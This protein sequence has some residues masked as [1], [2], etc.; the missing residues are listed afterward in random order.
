MY[1]ILLV[2]PR[3]PYTVLSAY[4]YCVHFFINVHYT[5]TMSSFEYV[6]TAANY[7]TYITVRLTT[8]LTK[9]KEVHIANIDI[10]L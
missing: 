2:L 5:L 9:Q 8:Q 4:M 7:S 3:I 6:A 1:A 10:S